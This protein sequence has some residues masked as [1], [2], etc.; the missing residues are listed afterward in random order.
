MPGP[1]ISQH[2]DPPDYNAFFALHRRYSEELLHRLDLL[3]ASG[4]VI[5]MFA[6]N[7]LNDDPNDLTLLLQTIAGDLAQ[8]ARQTA[9]ETFHKLWPA[10][11]SEQVS[12]EAFHA[13]YRQHW[14]PY[15]GPAWD[16]HFAAFAGWSRLKINA[17]VQY[18]QQLRI[19]SSDRLPD[20]QQELS[21]ADYQ[22][23]AAIALQAAQRC[24]D[25]RA[26]IDPAAF[27]AWVA[28]HWREE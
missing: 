24:D 5:A 17:L 7:I 13:A 14:H 2:L 11:I 27:D 9:Q 21:R 12:E 3:A 23:I 16:A 1:T 4:E 25:L 18:V 8:S 15:D 6:A 20:L 10:L 22:R 19:L 26:M 28:A